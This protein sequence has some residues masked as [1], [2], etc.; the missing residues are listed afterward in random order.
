MIRY[1]SSIQWTIGDLF[2]LLDEQEDFV[3]EIPLVLEFESLNDFL[4]SIED[5]EW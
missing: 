1:S 4:L 5:E 3:T 2:R